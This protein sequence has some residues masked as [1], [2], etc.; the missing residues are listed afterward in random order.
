[1]K[2]S[3][4]A[5]VSILTLASSSAWSEH[6]GRDPYR[7][8]SGPGMYLFGGA[9]ITSFDYEDVDH[10]FSFGDGSLSNIEVD[11]DTAGARVGLG[12]SFL[13]EL[14]LE[15][16]YVNL[17]ELEAIAT[18]NGSQALS[19]GYAPGRVF[20]EGDI[21]GAFVG[22]RIQSPMDEPFGL[23]AR[24]GVMAWEFSGTLEDSQ[25]RGDFSVEGSDP[26][27]GGGLRFAVGHNTAIEIGYEYYFL[28]DDASVEFAADRFS[29]DFVLHF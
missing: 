2:V 18:S 4:L 26:Y 24:A 13:P 10:R 11:N 25:Q 9:G 5:A 1:M 7:S 21:D 27:L 12:I 28:E 22:A 14:A 17:G 8:Q 6:Y 19:G 3:T 15:L 23:F 29:A 20:M 16:G